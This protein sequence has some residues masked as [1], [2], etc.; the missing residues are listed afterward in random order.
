MRKIKCTTLKVMEIVENNDVIGYW[1]KLG[2]VEVHKVEETPSGVALYVKANVLSGSPTYHRR[3]ILP[4]GGKDGS[5]KDNIRV[6]NTRLY[7][8]DCIRV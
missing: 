3:T 4:Y 2:G 5:H 7:L 8:E 1:E 6:Y